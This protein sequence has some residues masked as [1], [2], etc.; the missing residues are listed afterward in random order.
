MSHNHSFSFLRQAFHMK[1]M[2]LALFCVMAAFASRAEAQTLALRT[3]A[4]ADVTGVFNLGAEF[5]LGK[6]QT[7]TLDL[8]AAPLS[9]GKDRKLDL[10][11][12]RPEWRYWLSGE[13]FFG[14]YLGVH[15]LY[16]H[17]DAA[18]WDFV[19]A[20]KEYSF[21]GDI[22]GGG[23]GI[24]YNVPLGILWNLDVGA[25]FSACH[26]KYDK[27]SIATGDIMRATNT[28]FGPTRVYVS[29]VYFLQ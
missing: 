5:G 27:T 28:Y 4:L 6:R 21:K 16:S 20:F 7:L 25:S 15:G 18:G 26:M 12:V 13:T 22:K 9:Y 8:D 10:Y 2:A 11:G 3:N 24:G 19:D 17:Y 1:W 29:L 14:W 23:I